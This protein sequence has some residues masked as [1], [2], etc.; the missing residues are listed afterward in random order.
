MS[1]KKIFEQFFKIE[2]AVFTAIF[3]SSTIYYL[4]PLWADS[5]NV[6]IVIFDNLDST[7]VW[8]KLLTESGKTFAGSQEIIPNMMNGLPRLSYM[9]EF[10]ILVWLV[11]AFGPVKAYVINESLM[12]IVAFFSM[13][14]LLRHYFIPSD[15]P[16]RIVAIGLLSALF[17]YTP[18]WAGGMLSI[19]A[20]PLI[21]FALLRIRDHSDRW[22]EWIILLVLPFFTSFILVYFFF[23]VMMGGYLLIL[24]W[25]TGQLNMRLLA[26][27]LLL[28][29][30]YLVV[31]YR[32]VYDMLISSDFQSHRLE[33]VKSYISADNLLRNIH[34]AFL[35]GE[36]HT[37]YVILPYTA[38]IVLL[39]MLTSLI[40][41][42][43]HD[44]RAI[45]FVLI[46]ILIFIIDL[47]SMLLTQKSTLPLLLLFI[48]FIAWKS[49]EARMLATLF[50]VQLFFSAHYTLYYFEGLRSFDEMFPLFVQFNFSRFYYM[51]IP[52]WIIMLSQAFVILNRRVSHRWILPLLIIFS[53]FQ[54]KQLAKIRTFGTNGYVYGEKLSFR[55][56]FA[57]DLFNEI[58]DFIDLPKSSYRV[59]SF[60]IDPAIS[61]YNGYYTVDGY[62]TNYPR[63]YKHQFRQII[64]PALDYHFAAKNLFDHWGSKCYFLVGGYGIEHYNPNAS[65]ERFDANTSALYNLGGRYILSGYVIP[66]ATKH[67]LKFLKSFEH[68]E[69]I[70]KIRLY[71]ILKPEGTPL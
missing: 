20:L 70:W 21:F 46:V 59:V 51:S 52:L 28:L 42:Q 53:V 55:Q 29:S 22:P 60:G 69:T 50:L 65:I 47:W 43:L 8:L 27:L 37:A 14:I 4:Y 67:H 23:L 58:S 71:K 19:P 10:N 18:F 38:G 6:P 13:S 3:L 41:H 24:R 9:S 11:K 36:R 61:L 16:Y 2:P 48:I 44:W 66:E 45:T 64:A 17:S 15:T 30:T 56:Y 12:H 33:F 57:T 40:Q 5:T 49:R 32:L 63:S 68:V 34:L 35:N 31:E 1:H 26:A 7:F 54:A 25:Q 62:S 39:T